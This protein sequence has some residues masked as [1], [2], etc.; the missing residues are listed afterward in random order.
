MSDPEPWD[1][2][3]SVGVPECDAEH[4]ELLS[5]TRLV[6]DAVLRGAP[7]AAVQTLMDDLLACALAHFEHEEALLAGVGY[8]HLAEHRHAHDRLMRVLLHTKEDLRQQRY[9]PEVAVRFIRAWDLEH[10]RKVDAAYTP[11]FNG[12]SDS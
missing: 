4:A 7:L 12:A 3:P 1:E 8:P 5:R 2:S 9:S 10:I 6:A 11:Y